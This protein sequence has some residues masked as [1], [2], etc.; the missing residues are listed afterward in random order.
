MKSTFLITVLVALSLGISFAS[1]NLSKKIILNVVETNYQML[2]TQSEN[3]Q[4]DFTLIKSEGD[5][6]KVKVCDLEGNRLT[7]K[8]IK[9][10]NK[11]KTSFDL[12]ELPIGSYVVQVERNGKMLY[13]K[14]VEKK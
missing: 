2:L 13:S 12:S 3:S 7:T 10:N 9:R 5:V 8:R 4:V 1:E 11:T 6:F 14:Q